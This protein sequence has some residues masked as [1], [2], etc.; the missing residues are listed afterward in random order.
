M[1]VVQLESQVLQCLADAC[2]FGCLERTST[3]QH[4]HRD[5]CEVSTASASAPCSCSRRFS[6][7]QLSLNPTS[8]Q[9]LQVSPQPRHSFSTNLTIHTSQSSLFAVCEYLSPVSPIIRDQSSHPSPITHSRFSKRANSKKHGRITPGTC[10][11]IYLPCSRSFCSPWAT[12]EFVAAG[13]FLVCK[14]LIW[15]W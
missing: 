4:R 5:F 12:E 6:A 1:L 9:A 14:F 3:L 2:W 13:D 7:K 10:A 8:I 15:T 11:I